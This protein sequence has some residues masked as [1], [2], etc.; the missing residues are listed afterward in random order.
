MRVRPDVLFV[1]MG[2]PRQEY[3][4]AEIESGPYVMLG[5]GGSFDVLSGTKRD[6]PAWMQGRGLEW[7]FRLS[8]D[9]RLWRRYLVTNPWFV[10][11]VI[12]E[13]MRGPAAI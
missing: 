8:Q 6:A 7:L 1:A 3:W 2:S 11:Q 12:R 4:L 13:R 5:V 9:P 10:W